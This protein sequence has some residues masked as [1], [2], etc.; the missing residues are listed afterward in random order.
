M[1]NLLKAT[2]KDLVDIDGVGEII[3]ASLVNFFKEEKNL[4]LFNRLLAELELE[5]I[6]DNQ[7]SNILEGKVL[8]V[9]GSVN[10]FPNRNAVKELVESLGGKVTAS[11]TSKTN[12]LINNDS[13]SMSTKNKTA[14]KLGI[15]VITEE[16]FIKLIGR[17]DLLS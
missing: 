9:T 5:E 12:Y 16:E 3:A 2:V 13:K 10:I 17:E 8:V 7:T 4:S 1:I 15:P 6:I 14:A 11:V